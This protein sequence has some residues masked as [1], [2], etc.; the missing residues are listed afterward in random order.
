MKLLNDKSMLQERVIFWQCVL[1][2]IFINLIALTYL[3]S[4]L[5]PN[6]TPVNDA[7]VQLTNLE[8]GHFSVRWFFEKALWADGDRVFQAIPYVFANI[9][10]G[11]TLKIL[12]VQLLFINLLTAVGIF[13]VLLQFFQK[14]YLFCTIA[15]LLVMYYPGD[16]TMF[17]LG[18]FGVNLG[19]LFCVYSLL[20]F[21]RALEFRT[22]LPLAL[23]LLLLFASCRSYSGQ[24]PFLIS[25]LLVYLLLKRSDWKLWWWKAGIYFFVSAYFL[26]SY[27][28]NALSGRGREGAT[29]SFDVSSI[30]TGFMYAV[31]NLYIGT[32]KNIYT[33]E[34]DHIAIVLVIIVFGFFLFY[35]IDKN[36]TRASSVHA[37]E[38][39]DS[40]QK[41]L[42]VL[43]IVSLLIA[44]AGYAPF[45]VSSVRFGTERQLLFARPG[46]VILYCAILFILFEQI[47]RKYHKIESIGKPLVLALILGLS[48]MSK[49]GIAAEYA[50]DSE[51]QRIF[52]GDMAITMPEINENPSIVIYVE[53]HELKIKFAMLLNRPE[54][55]VRYL[56]MRN[57]L[58]VITISPFF[59]KRF[60]FEYDGEIFSTRGRRMLV[61][62]LVVLKYSLDEGFEIL[63]ELKIQNNDDSKEVIIKSPA[64][65][66]VEKRSRLTARQKWFVAERDRLIKKHGFVR[67]GT[68]KADWEI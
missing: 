13:F 23:S 18:A 42:T 36:N 68:K 53:T 3:W 27:A 30:F 50:R 26:A 15:S 47:G 6:Y 39:G 5:G 16:G 64:D 63:D 54:F 12:N 17:W 67:N 7:W 65:Y 55:P 46:V 43:A 1:G 38:R 49:G 14:K 62:N 9:F 34:Y 29:A 24:I 58:D 31:K 20:F 61:N 4:I 48:V 57:D 45:S 19:L 66:F 37:G 40:F 52:L 56:Y 60:G 35:I 51:I 11:D 25:V 21:F 59:L 44:I 32:L 41:Y 10:G 22:Y 33:I 8:V 28:A 2:V